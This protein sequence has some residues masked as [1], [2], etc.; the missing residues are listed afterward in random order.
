VEGNGARDSDGSDDCDGVVVRKRLQLLDEL[1]LLDFMS[2][3]PA[4]L[5]TR[6]LIFGRMEFCPF[7]LL[8]LPVA[9]G[10][11]VPVWNPLLR[12]SLC[13]DGCESIVFSA[14]A[15]FKAVSSRNSFMK[16]IASFL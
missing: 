11:A 9:D 14:S 3:W 8:L 10:L 7:A 15:S 13:D 5:S 4:I 2:F 1:E 12:L 6:L 16:R